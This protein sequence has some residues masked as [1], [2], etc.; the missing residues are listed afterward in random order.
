MKEYVLN[1]LS[2]LENGYGVCGVIDRRGRIYPLGSDTKVI[3]TLWVAT[4]AFYVMT[5]RI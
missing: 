4:P 2:G 5:A 3:S 1:Y